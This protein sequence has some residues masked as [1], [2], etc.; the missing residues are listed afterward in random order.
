MADEKGRIRYR[1]R[2]TDDYGRIIAELDP[3]QVNLSGRTDNAAYYSRYNYNQT[4]ADAISGLRETL[5]RVGMAAV[6]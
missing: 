2:G 4:L 1:Q 5:N 3:E 6:S